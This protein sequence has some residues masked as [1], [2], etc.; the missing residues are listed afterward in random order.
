MV[1]TFYVYPKKF[2]TW[3]SLTEDQIK[4]MS[5]HNME[6]GSHSMSHFDMGNMEKTQIKY[7]I[8]ESKKI[9]EEIT[10]KE[11]ESFCY[12]AGKYSTSVIEELNNTGYKSAVT[13]KYGF[14]S[15]TESP[16]EIKRI[17]I[18]YSDSLDV[19]VSRITN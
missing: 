4:E 5:D 6:F 12:P 10:G 19:F 17:R 14:Y 18:N 13:T 16:Y 1:G 9:L 7:E 11:I 8:E 2:G 15:F 3:N